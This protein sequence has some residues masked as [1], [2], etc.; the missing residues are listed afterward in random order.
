MPIML[1]DESGSFTDDDE[2]EM[3]RLQF[4]IDY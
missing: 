3:N 2:K 4:R 1:L